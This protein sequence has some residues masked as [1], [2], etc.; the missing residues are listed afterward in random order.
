MLYMTLPRIPRIGGH[1]AIYI[2]VILWRNWTITLLL[3]WTITDIKFDGIE[4]CRIY[5]AQNKSKVFHRNTWHMRSKHYTQQHSSNKLYLF[6][7]LTRSM[8]Y[9]VSISCIIKTCLKNVTGIVSC[10]LLLV[11]ESM[12][13]I[14]C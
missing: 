11:Y 10:L 8:F 7:S 2:V 4:H 6:Y 1:S 5:A 9:V 12:S 14:V 13:V 3:F